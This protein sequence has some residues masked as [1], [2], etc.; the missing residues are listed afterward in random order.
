[1][2]SLMIRKKGNYAG[3]EYLYSLLNNDHPLQDQLILPS[4]NFSV[5]ILFKY[6]KMLLIVDQH[7]CVYEW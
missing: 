2:T 6:F 1:M 7:Q 4:K 3:L 5:C